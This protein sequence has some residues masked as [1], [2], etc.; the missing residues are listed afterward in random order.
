MRL[1]KR[2][3]WQ[4]RLLK[5]LSLKRED[6]GDKIL[7]VH[8]THCHSEDRAWWGSGGQ[9]GATHS[10]KALEHSREEMVKP[11]KQRKREGKK[12]PKHFKNKH[13][14]TKSVLYEFSVNC[15]W[16]SFSIGARDVT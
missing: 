9:E 8:N 4:P 11:G 12:N 13:T 14:G 7:I 1:K 16:F 15:A 2:H 10:Q 5:M 3:S 6:G